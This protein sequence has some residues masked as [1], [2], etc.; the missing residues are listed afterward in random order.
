[1]LAYDPFAGEKKSPTN[2]HPSPAPEPQRPYKRYIV[3]ALNFL[4]KLLAMIGAAIVRE[5]VHRFFT[6]N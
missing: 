3:L 5:V 6:R 1:M 2:T 4:P